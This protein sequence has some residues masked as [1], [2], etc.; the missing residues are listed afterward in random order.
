MYMK[1]E[2]IEIIENNEEVFGDAFLMRF[3]TD[4][5]LADAEKVLG[6]EI[7][8]EYVWFLK[9]YGHGGF[10][11]E[12]L[13]YG[14]NG[15]AIFVTKNLHEREFG[16]PKELLVIEDC[17]EYVHCIDTISKA[18]VSWS[19]HD[20]DGIIKVADDFY[21]YFLDNIDNAIENFD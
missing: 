18:I 6:L 8:E 3:P 16:L 11:F 2:I 13:G 19:K 21:K 20:N 17:D 1:N 14:L 15:N 4:E 9:T 7:P 10:F 12:F 5:E